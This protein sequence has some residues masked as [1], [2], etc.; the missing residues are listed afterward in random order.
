MKKVTDE[1]FFCHRV[2]AWTRRRFLAI[3]VM[4]AGC[5]ALF[6]LGLS[7]AGSKKGRGAVPGAAPLDSRGRM[8]IGGEDRCPVCGMKVA[9]YA[10]FAAA[11][12][13][14]DDTTYYFCGTGCMIR[15]WMH[16]DIFLGVKTIR[17][18]QSVVQDYFSGEHVDG[19]RVT[20]VAGSDVVGPMGPALVPL[21]KSR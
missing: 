17:L 5:S 11:I 7:L 6:P 4:W 21:K 14:S 15:S 12:Q 2:D 10:K 8:Q 9:R 1:H 16:P 3:T 13:L 20:W 18:K 19:R